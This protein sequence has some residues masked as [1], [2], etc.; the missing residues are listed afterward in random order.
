MR[1]SLA[2]LNFPFIFVFDL[3]EHVSHW[4]AE[5]FKF[6]PVEMAFNRSTTGAFC[7]LLLAFLKKDKKKKQKKKKKTVNLTWN[8]QSTHFPL[9]SN[10]E[11]DC[12]AEFER[13]RDRER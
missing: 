8:H 5:N 2:G 13:G 6:K 4:Q 10:L 11:I 12:Q 9:F 7:L 3:T 1:V